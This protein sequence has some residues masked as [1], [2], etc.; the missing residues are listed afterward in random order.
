MGLSEDFFMD[1]ESIARIFSEIAELLDLKGEN[2]FKIKAYQKAS[3]VV[4]ALAQPLVEHGRIEELTQ[5][6][7][8][9]KSIAEKILEI[10]AAGD[11][12]L[13]REL[14][15]EFPPQILALLSVPALGPKKAAILYREL[16]IGSLEE[17]K[18]AAQANRI[19]G[20]KGFG[21]KTQ[22]N[23]LKGV[24]LVSALSGRRSIAQALPLARE[25]VKNLAQLPQ[26][27]RVSEAGSLRRRK[28][29]IGDLD[30]LAA[31]SS[32]Q[33][34]MDHFVHQAGVRQIIAQGDT[35]S[36]ILTQDN[37]QVD[38]RVVEEEA[39]GSALQYF[40]GSKDHNVA[41][42]GLARDLDL[43]INEYGVFGLNR[44]Q[45]LAG[46]TEE[47]VYRSVGLADIPPELREDRGEIQAARENRLPVLV[48]LSEIKGDFHLHSDYSDGTATIGEMAEAAQKL[49]YQYM[50]LTDH[51]QSLRIAGGLSPERL[52]EQQ[53]E[54]ERVQ[55]R[56]APF[57][58][59]KGTE[60]DILSDGSLDYPPEI[61]AGFDLVI[62]SVHSLMKMDK[63][64]MTARIK[65]AVENPYITV[66][67][68]PTGRIIG[69]RDEFDVDWDEIYALCA[70]KRVA[71]E[72]NAFPDRLDLRDIYCQRAREFGC[73]FSI[74]TDAHSPAHLTNMEFGV[75]TARRGWLESRNIL[76][77]MNLEELETWLRKDRNQ[78]RS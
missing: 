78:S 76:N 14:K 75:F 51:S 53:A 54:I 77:C 44:E 18:A 48:E 56:L 70:E 12:A 36:S 10:I 40:T 1:N 37:W 27:K 52:K 32:P 6:P 21:E 67:G 11:C 13:H 4:S 39:Y 28:E 3:R 33:E 68:H 64:A 24:A 38:L 71:L 61:L 62:A 45:P 50:V 66:L 55:S 22:E 31:S 63:A 15:A 17:L 25:M 20:L 7:G 42:R 19:S 26:V 29:T 30:I 34:V 72:I 49:G 65:K 73:L 74:G 47:E 46:K 43:K 59:F 60:V 23:I 57:R 8:I 41:L 9:G 58:I 35:K 5:I 16:G 69:Q 2:S